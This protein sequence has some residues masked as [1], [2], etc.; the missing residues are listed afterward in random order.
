MAALIAACAPA[1]AAQQSTA[2]GPTG[3]L[4]ISQLA[5]LPRG[6]P[7]AVTANA[8]HSIVYSVWDPLSRVDEQGNT[9]MYLAES[10]TQESPTTWVVKLR[11]DAKWHDGVP[12]TAADVVFSIDYIRDA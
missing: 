11:K 7:Y 2:S 4:T 8:E 10:W 6:D 9:K 1:P 12:F 3:T 5:L